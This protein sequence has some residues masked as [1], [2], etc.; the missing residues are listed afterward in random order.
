MSVIVLNANYQFWSEVSIKKAIKWM[1]LNKIEIVESHE[2]E[3][4]RAVELR[5]KMPL[6]VRLLNLVKYRPKHLR[7]P[8]STTAVYNRDNNVCQYWHYDDRGRKYKY[9]CSEQDR[10]IDHIVPLSRGGKNDFENC[11]C[12]CRSCNELI[13][14]NRL[15]S[16]V[17]LEL[18][19][20]PFAPLRSDDY[21][22][23][24]RFTYNERKLS[25]KVYYEKILGA[26]F[27]HVIN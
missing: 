12:C 7:V 21:I 6:V 25:H 16:E 15:P 18:M 22:T 13:K 24:M 9:R 8:F 23:V 14:K 10:T 3:E 4:I 1:I 20:K 26:K 17:G 5:V 19:R 2:S 27:S 11:V